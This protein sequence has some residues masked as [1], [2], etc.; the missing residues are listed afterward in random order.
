MQG[1]DDQHRSD[2]DQDAERHSLDQVP[3][4][5]L[6]DRVHRATPSHHVPSVPVVFTVRAQAFRFVHP[7]FGKPNDTTS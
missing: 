5:A 1:Q 2:R 7:G 4:A 3:P 6:R